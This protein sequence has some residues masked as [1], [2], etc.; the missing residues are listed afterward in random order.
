MTWTDFSGAGMERL[1]VALAQI[2]G[3]VG[4][5]AGN[6]TRMRKCLDEARRLGVDVVAFPELAVPWRPADDLLLREDFV[7]A[8]RHALSELVEATGGLTAVVGFV[9]L[10]AGNRFDAAAVLHDGALVGVV[11][12]E[13][14]SMLE[15]F[16]DRRYFSPG[17]GSALFQIA[18]IWVGIVIGEDLR[19]PLGPVADLANAGAQVILGIDSAPFLRGQSLERRRLL[20]TRAKEHEVAIAYVNA[21]GGQDELVF[22]GGSTIVDRSGAIL[23]E[24]PLFVEELL[25]WDIEV[26]SATASPPASVG[27]PPPPRHTLS[28]APRP[29]AR[30]SPPAR[31]PIQ[32]DDLAETYQALVVGLRD[33]VTKNGIPGV[34]FGLSGGIDSALVATIAV[35]ALGAAAVKGVS[36]PSRYSSEG[37]R[38]DAEAQAA[39][40]GFELRSIPIEPMFR[41]A[42]DTLAPEF[43]DHGPD[44][45]E[46]NLQARIRGM[47]LMALSNKFGWLVLPTSNKSET[48]VGYSTLYGDMAGGFAILK[49]VPKTLV[50]ELARWRNRQG[51]EAVIPESV[52]AK[53]PS[54]ELRP[55]QFDTDSLPPYEVLDPILERYVEED[56]SVR[57]LIEAGYEPDLVRRIVGLVERSEF[58]RRQAAPGIRISRRAFG[59][60]RRMPMTS[61][62][63]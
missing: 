2:N 20:T 15:P 55:D 45:T 9:D 41:S 8:N 33:Y 52:I 30:P 6:V 32:H 36:M 18:G 12:K 26:P 23:A 7:E 35:D 16:D 54:A 5:F 10:E 24:A 17:T 53:P 22:D 40:L 51:P 38:I 14:L 25:V 48:A 42:L 13:H 59:I 49:D 11:R 37:S 29:G 27:A 34:V 19:S 1:R 28:T 3:T 44:V 46:E 47:I 39:V 56:W 62:F 61:R 63:R 60:D 58:K 21:A 43:R 4:D 31:P 50:Y 57:Q